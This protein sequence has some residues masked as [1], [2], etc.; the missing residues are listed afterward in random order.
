MRTKRRERKDIYELISF[1]VKKYRKEAHLTQ[2]QLAE[3]CQYSHEFIRRIEAPNVKKCFSV[4]T[5]S[6]IAEALEIDIRKLF[7]KIEDE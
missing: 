3:K 4:A 2:A 5:I 7:D 1:N 6:I